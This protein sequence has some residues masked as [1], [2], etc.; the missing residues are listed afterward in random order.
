MTDKKIPLTAPVEWFG[1]RLGHVILREPKAG[2]LQ[3]FG[4]PR[5]AIHMTDGSGAVYFADRDDVIGRYFD[6][7]LSFEGAKPNDV[8][9]EPLLNHLSLEDAITLRDALFDF[10]MDARRRIASKRATSS[11]STSKSSRSPSAT[12]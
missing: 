1:K 2:D 4:E 11:S 6:A 8:A 3:R 12:P 9:G 7:L 5:I 10:F